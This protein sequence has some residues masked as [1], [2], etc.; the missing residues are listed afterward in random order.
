VVGYG[1]IMQL[2]IVVDGDGFGFALDG[3][4]ICKISQI[5]KVGIGANDTIDRSTVDV[6]KE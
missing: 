6:T 2:G 1:V 3:D 5:G 4:K